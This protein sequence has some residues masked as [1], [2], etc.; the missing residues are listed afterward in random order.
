MRRAKV[1]KEQQIQLIM[2]CRRSGLSDY[3][4]CQKNDIN[5]GTFYNWI[6][7][8]RKDGYTIPDPAIQIQA[9]PVTQEVV[10]VDL[11]EHTSLILPD[12][13]QN[14]SNLA[15]TYT[16]DVAAEIVVGRTTIRLFNNASPELLKSIL[17][18]FGGDSK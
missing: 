5:P 7:R 14:T 10:K 6:T 17:Q 9:Q 1:S 4:W 2:E 8:F 12:A 16:T 18:C 13:E 15:S 11:L 3:Q